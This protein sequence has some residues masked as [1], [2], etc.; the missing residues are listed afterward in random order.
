MDQNR[1]PVRISMHIQ[2]LLKNRGF[3][4]DQVGEKKDYR[5]L[6]EHPA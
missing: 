1:E 4:A 6:E 5:E 3:T 2:N